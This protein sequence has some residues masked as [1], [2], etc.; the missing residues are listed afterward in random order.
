MLEQHKTMGVF[1]SSF[2]LVIKGSSSSF[3]EYR[4]CVGG[5]GGSRVSQC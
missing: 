3:G 1:G 4:D 5:G 2:G